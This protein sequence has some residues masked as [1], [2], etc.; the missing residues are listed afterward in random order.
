MAAKPYGRARRLLASIEAVAGADVVAQV[1]AGLDEPNIAD[2]PRKKAEWSAAVLSRL[3]AVLP[4][5]TCREIM[6][7]RCCS[8]SDNFAKREQAL[9]ARSESLED[10]ARLRR[11][12]GWGGFIAEG[13]TL[14]VQLAGDRCHCLP[15][16][17]TQVPISPTYCL[18][19]VGHLTQLLQATFGMPVEVEI[20]ESVIRGGSTCWLRGHIGGKGAAVPQPPQSAV[21]LADDPF[22]PPNKPLRA[23]IVPFPSDLTAEQAAGLAEI[24][25]LLE[26]IATAAHATTKSEQAAM[27]EARYGM[28]GVLWS[29]GLTG[30]LLDENPPCLYMEK[31]AARARGQHMP[32]GPWATDLMRFRMPGVTADVADKKLTSPKNWEIRLRFDGPEGGLQVL[33]ALQWYVRALVAAYG[34]VEFVGS[35]RYKGEA[36]DRFVRADM[37]LAR[38][39]GTGNE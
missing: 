3:E 7:R 32:D 39:R 29:L 30:E 2:S 25:R 34:P 37:D 36:Y 10:F 1:A 28:W 19:C 26:A 6:R 23:D 13:N 11:E 35:R 9:W 24:H 20:E 27:R 12:L 33:Q 16:Y 21:A 22:A 31:R 18:C 4:V 8:V 14:R 17:G 15:Q 5:E 38:T